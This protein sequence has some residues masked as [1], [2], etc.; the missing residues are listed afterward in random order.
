MTK[1]AG[2]SDR[3]Q[4]ARERV[5]ALEKKLSRLVIVMPIHTVASNGSA[6]AGNAQAGLRVLRDGTEVGLAQWGTALPIDPGDHLIA[7]SAT[8]KKPWQTTASV[9][10]T[11]A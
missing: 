3:E 6:S 5:A 1:A 4:V 8:G 11:G 7:V 10:P 2:Q 9:P